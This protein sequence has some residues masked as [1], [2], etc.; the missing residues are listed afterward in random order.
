MGAAS[1]GM[2][3][4]VV[5][6]FADN[7]VV[8]ESIVNIADLDPSYWVYWLSAT[9]YSSQAGEEASMQ[10]R[11]PSTCRSLGQTA[12]AL[13]LGTLLMCAVCVV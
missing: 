13:L 12:G 6:S 8:H 7:L 2:A 5:T 4:G 9:G 3:K 10:G 1:S 11:M